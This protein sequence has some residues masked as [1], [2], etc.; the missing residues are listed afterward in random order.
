M[1]SNKYEKYVLNAC[2]IIQN[3][4]LFKKEI[5]KTK[6]IEDAIVKSKTSVSY[7]DCHNII[8]ELILNL[9]K[10]GDQHSKFKRYN[11]EL[12]TKYEDEEINV[13]P[14]VEII[15]D[16]AYIRVSS[17]DGTDEKEIL[18]FSQNLHNKMR[19]IS[20][21]MLKGF[22]IDLRDNPGGNMD[23]MILGLGFL[24][25]KNPCAFF[26]FPD[27]TMHSWGYIDG[28]YY[29]ND[30]VLLKI[31]KPFILKKRLPV[32]ILINEKTAS[33]A[34]MLTVSLLYKDVR[35]FGNTTKNRTT[36]NAVYKFED[37]SKL[38]LSTCKLEGLNGKDF[39]CGINPDIRVSD[40][41]AVEKSI[42]WI[43]SLQ[44]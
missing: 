5:N 24:V 23:P 16:C 31:P 6:I 27:G 41:E 15:K 1:S 18:E 11:P 32:A 8:D 13:P 9:R 20:E 39:L 3:D 36:G 25:E 19:E 44:S 2:E 30:E 40:S 4:S 7:A 38:V 21:K 12:T 17:F 35:L 10:L 43:Y 42:Q 28:K 37:K 33:S 29:Y 14:E 22:I 26:S 34:E